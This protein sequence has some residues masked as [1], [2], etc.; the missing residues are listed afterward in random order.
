MLLS[1]LLLASY[2]SNVIFSLIILLFV[3]IVNNVIEVER[4]LLLRCLFIYINTVFLSSIVSCVLMLVGYM[5]CKKRPPGLS[6]VY[7][8]RK[9]ILFII[10]LLHSVYYFIYFIC[11]LLIPSRDY[12]THFFGR[13]GI[14][15]A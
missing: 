8:A 5:Y 1:T 11:D 7:R 12:Q 3:A 9:E 10:T 14:S 15:L 6:T 2:I 13:A 4:P